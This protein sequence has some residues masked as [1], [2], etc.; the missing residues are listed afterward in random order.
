MLDLTSNRKRTRDF[1]GTRADFI[2]DRIRVLALVFAAMVLLWT[3]LDYFTIQSKET[4]IRLAVLRILCA[5]LYLALASYGTK[6]HDL[7]RAHLKLASLVIL[8]CLFYIASRFVLEDAGASGALMLYTFFPFVVVVQL[9]I[10]PLPLL[11]GLALMAPAFVTLI[12][13]EAHFASLLSLS[14]LGDLSLLVLLACLALWAS[15]SELQMLLRLYRQATHDPLTGLFNRGALMERMQ[16]EVGRVRQHGHKLCVL[17]FD[18]DKFKRINDDHGHLTGDVVL[19][20]FAQ[21][22]ERTLR[23]SDL[24]GRYGGEEFLALLPRTDTADAERLAEKIRKMCAET[25]IDTHDG[26]QLHFTTSAG[27]AQLRHDETA[28]DLLQRVDESLYEAKEAG[29]DR[30]ILAA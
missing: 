24:A 28:Q 1:L 10:F 30:V 19:K 15:M 18:L 29:R 22:M 2:Q 14:F 6:P 5:G 12:V 4:V 27:I 17:L 23:H 21:I 8:P 26:D 25:P 3:T 11:E 7:P 20:I 9:A 16:L 13:V